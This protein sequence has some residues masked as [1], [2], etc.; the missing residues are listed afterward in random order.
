VNRVSL[1]LQ[2]AD[3]AILRGV[4]RPEAACAEARAGVEAL[5]A[6]GIGLLNVDL[7][8]ALPGD[9]LQTWL[10][11]VDFALSLEPDVVTTY[12]TVYKNRAIAGDA[13]RRGVLPGADH[14]GRLYDAGFSRLLAAGYRAGYGSVNFSRVPG[15]LGTSRYLEGRILDG[16]DYVG[17][18]LYASSLLNRAWAFAPADYEAWLRAARS[19]PLAAAEVY[20]LPVEHV[21]AKYLLLALSYGFVDPGRF[22]QRFAEPLRRRFGDALDWLGAAGQLEERSGEWR[23]TPGS[24]SKL[25]GIRAAFYPEEAL[26]S[27]SLA[28]PSPRPDQ[29]AGPR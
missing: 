16:I 21:M 29:A 27:L 12:D 26:G 20:A 6:S 3:P 1:G 9:S 28:V 2:S 22:E 14:Y 7:M 25:P 19:G 13:F 23:M 24:F 5:R 4:G 10:E 11:A 17:V 8:F 15:R 18:G